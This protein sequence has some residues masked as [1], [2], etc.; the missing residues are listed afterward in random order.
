MTM[1]GF[2]AERSLNRPRR[3]HRQNTSARASGNTV[4]PQQN[5]GP[6]FDWECLTYCSDRNPFDSSICYDSCQIPCDPHAPP[7]MLPPG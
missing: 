7:E 3:H 5:P 1:P 4:V 2:T 6:C